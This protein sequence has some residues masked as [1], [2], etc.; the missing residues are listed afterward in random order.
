MKRWM[1]LLL[2]AALQTSTSLHAQPAK[3]YGQELVDRTLAAHRELASAAIETA[4]MD[5]AAATVDRSQAVETRLALLDATGG[6]VGTLVLAFRNAGRVSDASL[7]ARAM[8]IRDALARRIL[9]AANLKDPFPYSPAVATQTRAQAIVDQVQNAHPDVRVLAL[10]VVDRATGE[11]RLAGSTFGRHGKKADADDLKVMRAGGPATDVFSGGRRFGVDLPLRGADGQPIGT[12]NVGYA[13]HAGDDRTQLL[14][15]ALSLR[16]E[17]EL[18]IA[19]EKMA[20][21]TG[22]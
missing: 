7:I 1:A 5:P 13:L 18:R 6:P 4:P 2:A 15:R 14:G 3:T 21:G 20:P 17:V 22:R 8:A 9:N 10:R 11:L 19:Q 16:R 12:M